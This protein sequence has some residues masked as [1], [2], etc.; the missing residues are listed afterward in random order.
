LRRKLIRGTSFTSYFN[1]SWQRVRRRRFFIDLRKNSGSLELIKN[2]PKDKSLHQ[3]EISL[4]NTEPPL[5]FIPDLSI[6]AEFDVSYIGMERDRSLYFLNKTSSRHRYLVRVM[7]NPLQVKDASVK[8]LKLTGPFRAYMTRVGIDKNV[9]R[10]AENLASGSIT[11]NQSVQSVMNYLKNNCTYSLYENFTGPEDPVSHFLF[12]SRAGSCEHFASAMTLM[13]RALRIPARPVNGYTMGDWNELGGFFTVRQRH[14]HSWVEVYFPE[15]GWV[16]FDP[17]PV[18][19]LYEPESEIERF[20]VQLW[21]LY[22]GSWFTYVYNFDHQVQMAGFKKIVDEF[23]MMLGN[24]YNF[25]YRL[26]FLLPLL[27]IYYYIFSRYRM[28]RR[29][30][31]SSWLPDWYLDWCFKLEVKRNEWETPQEF[32]KR[33]IQSGVFPEDTR[34]VLIELAN[35]INLSLS[36]YADRKEIDTQAK[37]LLSELKRE[38]K[39]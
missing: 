15:S 11:I 21:E 17:S 7:I 36:K 22:E 24:I 32:H 10:L 1:G 28:Q 25:V 16:P 12:N 8:N 19:D 34:K 2:V 26:R 6:S 30:F 3:L 20:L 27:L 4:E 39:I 5:I 29:F 37:K 23:E 38:H 31:Y 35:L 18:A 33:L 14:A 9:L 13:L